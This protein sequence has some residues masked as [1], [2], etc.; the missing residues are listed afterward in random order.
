M[1]IGFEDTLN[2]YDKASNIII[3]LGLKLTKIGIGSESEP[4]KIISTPQFFDYEKFIKDDSKKQL[5]LAEENKKLTSDS[6]EENNLNNLNN[7]PLS[8]PNYT[9]FLSSNYITLLGYKKDL[10]KLKFPLESFIYNILYTILQ[11]KKQQRDKNYNCLL[12]LD[13]SLHPILTDIYELIVKLILENPLISQIKL[14]PKSF[15]PIFTTGF[16]SGIVIDVGYL[17]TSIVP[18]NNGTP[19]LNKSVS[20]DI[21]SCHLE[22]LLNR[23][24]IE[25]NIISP[26]GKMR[27]IKNV[28]NFCNNL[29]KYL[30]DLVVRSTVV[31]NKKLSILLAEGN[32]EGGLKNETDYSKVDYC[33]D[34]QDF[35]ISFSTR[36]KLGEKFFEDI[37]GGDGE[38]NICYSLLK[39]ILSL[40][41]EDRRKLS[42]NIILSGGGSMLMGFYR[43]FIDEIVFLL[44]C[45]EFGELKEIKDSIKVHKI[46][47]ARN[48]LTWIGAS[49]MSSFE[50]LNL[51][52]MTIVKEDFDV[53]NNVL[54]T[55]NNVQINEQEVVSKI[56]DNLIEENFNRD[57]VERKPVHKILNYFK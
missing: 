10:Q 34:L 56:E 20:L 4:R 41:N 32:S 9:N 3:D 44:D 1:N 12:I 48:C 27:K 49:L 39:V 21:G 7:Q 23:S 55:S 54:L 18:I 31:V 45:E 25:E 15:L 26:I 51:K 30:D 42:G 50:K 19:Y 11:L 2:S 13:F 28:E 36:V 43:R 35:S 5:D 16:S 8:S 57:V 6:L 24:I 17:S 38:I 14:L 53:K 37:N 46:L 29:P 22:K 40:S 52:Q 33:K 47:F